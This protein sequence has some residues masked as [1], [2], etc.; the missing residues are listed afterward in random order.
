MSARQEGK[1][2]V[3][4][5]GRAPK[6]LSGARWRLPSSMK[7]CTRCTTALYVASGESS[8]K[9]FQTATSSSTTEGSIVLSTTRSSIS[10][11]L[12]PQ[13]RSSSPLSPQH[14]ANTTPNGPLQASARSSSPATQHKMFQTPTLYVRMTS[15]PHIRCKGIY[16]P[17]EQPLAL[18]SPRV[19]FF[20]DALSSYRSRK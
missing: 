14:I 1:P 11:T 18:R 13:S 19:W 10:T 2:P 5:E 15:I 8:T 7:E 3:L 16:Q 9:D 6:P 4:P 17:Q 12:G 20:T